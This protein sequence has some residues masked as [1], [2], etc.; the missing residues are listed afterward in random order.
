MQTLQKKTE[1][2]IFSAPAILYPD[3]SNRKVCLYRAPRPGFPEADPEMGS[4][5]KQYVKACTQEDSWKAQLDRDGEEVQKVAV[6]GKALGGQLHPH[7][8]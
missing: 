3:T 7:F 1:H 2:G 5:Y 6:S 4:L 8:A